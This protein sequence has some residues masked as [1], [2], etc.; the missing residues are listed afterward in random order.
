MSSF[1]LAS[2]SPRRRHLLSMAG[3]RFDVDPSDVDETFQD[4]EPTVQ[5]V[6]LASLKAADVAARHPGR[7]VLA[8]DTIVIFGDDQLAKPTDPDDAVR[9]LRRLSGH[10]HQVV[11][12]VCLRR[13]AT[14]HAFAVTTLVTFADL[15]DAEIKAYVATGSPMDKAG[16]YGIQDDMGAL[17]VERI[18]GCY[19]N[20]VGLPLHQVYTM[21]KQVA[22][23][24]LNVEG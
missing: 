23:E 11:T 13:D 21:M 4:L 6:R 22:A 18:N 20:V 24:L 3:F 16:A 7:W 19:Y 8:A 10:T 17:F 12:G 2:A 5:A 1:V 14:E 15:S 9:M